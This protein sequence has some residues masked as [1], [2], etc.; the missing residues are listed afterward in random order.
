MPA[1]HAAVTSVRENRA[2]PLAAALCPAVRTGGPREIK[3]ARKRRKKSKH[4]RY[5][6]CKMARVLYDA[7]VFKESA[8]MSDSTGRAKGGHARAEKLSPEERSEIARRGAAA[9]HR[10]GNLREAIYGSPDRPLRIGDVTIQCYVLDDETR[11]LSQAEFL[12]A[13]GRH[14]RATASIHRE[15]QIPPILQGKGIRSFISDDLLEKSRPVQFRPPT[16]GR[17]SGYRAEV[18]PAVCEVYLRARDAGILLPHQMR[19]AK[20][21]EILIRALAHVGIIALVDEATGFQR[22]R[23]KEALAQILEAFIA[24]ELQ[25]YIQTFPADFYEQIFRLRGLEYPT[26]KVKRPQYF[27]I[28]TNDIVYKRL[29]PGVLEELKKVTP[30]SETGRPKAKLFQS[31]TANIGYPKLREHLGSVVTIMKFSSDWQDFTRKLDRLH[32][33]YGDTMQLPLEY[34]RDDGKGL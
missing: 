30:R 9:R 28:I 33:R 12:E 6:A 15:E 22:E 7:S 19:I 27:G 14:R 4:R 32:P 26:A 21:A 2:E 18:L 24:K 11:V 10:T 25:A 13:M 8:C 16:G 31:L 29:A 3:G 23:A 20:Q 5:L 17:A 1:A 34:E